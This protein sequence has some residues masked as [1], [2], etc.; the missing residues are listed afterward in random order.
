M[1]LAASIMNKLSD[2]ASGSFGDIIVEWLPLSIWT[3]DT[4][5]HTAIDFILDLASTTSLFRQVTIANLLSE[6]AHPRAIPKLRQ[7]PQTFEGALEISQ[8]LSHLSTS[9]LLLHEEYEFRKRYYYDDL[10]LQLHMEEKFPEKA[11]IAHERLS[12]TRLKLY[13]ILQENRKN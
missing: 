13:K 5:N 12:D 3:R 6:L 4:N 2:Y 10:I 8:N 11:P 7:L 9:D 1:T